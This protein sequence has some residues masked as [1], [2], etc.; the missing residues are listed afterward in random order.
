MNSLFTKLFLSYWLAMTVIAG[1]L[2]FAQYNWPMDHG[3]PDDTAMAGHAEELQRLFGE[4]RMAG[5][6]AY[7]RALNRRESV[8]YV[9]V[10]PQ[11]RMFPMR[12]QAPIPHDELHRMM[13]DPVREGRHMRVHAV[14]LGHNEFTLV[15]HAPR[16]GA[17]DL[18]WWGRLLV[19]LVV[20]ALLAALLARQ[21]SLPVRRVRE[22]SRKLAAGDL[23]AR[24]ADSGARG[25]D[26]ALLGHD[27]NRMAERLQSLLQARNEL[28]RD[29]SHELRSPLARLQVALELGR[30]Q[31]DDAA[32]DR[33]E[34]EIERMDGLI[35]ELLALARL[36]AGSA[37]LRRDPV[38]LAELL[39]DVCDDASF[40]AAASD[41]TVEL[42]VDGPAWLLGD[43][44]L[45]QSAFDNVIRNAMRHTPRGTT[46]V[47]NLSVRGGHAAVA[48]TDQG[49]GIP[50]PDLERIF[51]PFVRLSAARER[52]TGG[53]GLGLA[54]AY[55]ALR[56]HGGDISAINA[57]PRGLC[58]TIRLPLSPAPSAGS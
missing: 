38:D 44:G 54:I 26:M 56:L 35:G 36:E 33:I 21:L 17:A 42:K 5:V 58:V 10:D 37:P 47:V 48:V 30:S 41:R 43:A 49:P 34:R 53:H 51:E 11:G 9:L 20:T 52:E 25:D 57:E 19:A 7:M 40:E 45:L 31:L 18:P 13:A 55:R 3:L 6:A 16:R 32:F 29:I 24:V 23:D 1:A 4:E 14:T 46:V 15:A 28:L 22:A 50:E 39:R 8:R 2:L 12:R 27:F